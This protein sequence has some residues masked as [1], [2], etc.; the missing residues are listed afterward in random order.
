MVQYTQ[1]NTRTVKESFVN[2]RV[3]EKRLSFRDGKLIKKVEVVE[4]E[5]TTIIKNEPV[6][7]I[8]QKKSFKDEIS[9]TPVT[10]TGTDYK[11]R[12]I[13]RY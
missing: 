12:Q 6:S 7:S 4:P 3:V 13:R 9:F 11:V 8:I 5:L 10:L 1:P 2:N